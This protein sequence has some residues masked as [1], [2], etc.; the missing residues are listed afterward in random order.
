[1]LLHI[2]IRSLTDYITQ[3]TTFDAEQSKNGDGCAW[4]D[5]NCS[6]C[7][8]QKK[9]T[10]VALKTCIWNW[11]ISTTTLRNFFHLDTAKL[12]IPLHPYCADSSCC[13]LYLD[14]QFGLSDGT[15]PRWDKHQTVHRTT[16][17]P[18]KKKNMHRTRRYEQPRSYSL[19]L[20]W[21]SSVTWLFPVAEHSGRCRG[22]RARPGRGCL[23]REL[24]VRRA[25]P[26][27]GWANARTT[28]HT[29]TQM[30]EPNSEQK[31]QVN[32]LKWCITQ[33]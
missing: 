25:P 21:E 4:A 12:M 8:L 14:L 23:T 6:S 28:K 1:M 3:F 20:R 32:T 27:S 17:G 18:T 9:T 5:G 33:A 2:H 19:S 26:N 24:G 15:L 16:H 29:R 13:F 10:H 22:G 7:I 30:N 31:T 11:H